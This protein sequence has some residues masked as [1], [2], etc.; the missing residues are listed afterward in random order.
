[1]NR[2]VMSVVLYKFHTDTDVKGSGRRN[3][4]ARSYTFLGRGNPDDICVQDSIQI[5]PTRT[6]RDHTKQPIPHADK[7]PSRTLPIYPQSLTLNISL[8]ASLPLTPVSP[9][10]HASS[11]LGMVVSKRPASAQ[12]AMQ[13]S[14]AER[15]AGHARQYEGCGG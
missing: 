7:I 8:S 15:K 13:E 11:L 5:Y 9:G 1:V 12:G 14:E 6:S 2:A 3:A 10:L 4:T